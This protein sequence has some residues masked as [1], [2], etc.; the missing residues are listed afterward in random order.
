MQ[1]RHVISPSAAPSVRVWTLALLLAVA[2]GLA[3][4]GAAVAPSYAGSRTATVYV[5]QGLPGRSVDVAVGGKTVA[6][7]LRT[8]AVAGPFT[9]PAG[10]QT[11]TFSDGGTTL[12]SRRFSVTDRSNWDVVLHLP[13]PSE[14]KPTVTVFRNDLASVARG[15]ASLTVAHT[16]AVPPADVRVDGK[17]LFSDIANGQSLNLVV[18]VATYKVAITP[19]GKP[20][21]IYLG[22]VNLTVKGGALNRVYALGDPQ[23]NTMNVAVHVIATGASGSARPTAVDTGTGGEAVG[24]TRFLVKLTR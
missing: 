14:S 21:P 7:R 3:S 5:V 20:S 2:L 23:K 12:L 13:A 15:K 19:R 22:P 16:A 11:V 10:S 18:P 9:V 1:P 4:A 6:K 24:A 8:A 17:V